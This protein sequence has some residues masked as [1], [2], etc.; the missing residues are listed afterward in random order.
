VGTVVKD[1]KNQTTNQHVIVNKFAKVMFPLMI[2]IIIT[3][4]YQS[5]S[6]RKK[7]GAQKA[8]K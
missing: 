6:K 8:N 7:T 3:H 2:E 1:A 5:N 4:L